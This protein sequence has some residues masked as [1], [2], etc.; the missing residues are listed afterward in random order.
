MK[1]EFMC[2]I[3]LIGL[4]AMG[5]TSLPPDNVK[6]T[7]QPSEFV[8]AISVD[9]VSVVNYVF[10]A[11]DPAAL[12]APDTPAQINWMTEI[13]TMVL[14]VNSELSAHEMCSSSLDNINRA[15]CYLPDKSYN[16]VLIS[17]RDKI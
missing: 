3:L 1:K 16:G 17:I 6:R 14:S 15:N 2:L 13:P 11:V 10:S 8:Q 5:F 12:P 4:F 9:Q 7:D